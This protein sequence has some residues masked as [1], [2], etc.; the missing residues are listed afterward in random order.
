L[1]HL[2]KLNGDL[3]AFDSESGVL[4]LLDEIAYAVLEAWVENG[5]RK[6]SGKVLA[7]LADQ[8]GSPA[9]ECSVEIEEAAA[10]GLMFAENAPVDISQLY[11]DQPRIKSMCLHL[12]HDCN[13]RCKYCFAGTG[14]FGTGKRSMLDVETGRKAVDFLIEASGPRRNLDIDFFGG[15]PLLNWPVVVA[16]TDY[17]EKKAAETG[18]DIRLTITTNAVLLDDEKTEFINRHFKNCVLSIDGRPEVHDRMRPDAGRHGSYD[19]VAA[20]IRSF[21]AARGD[22]EYYLRGTYTHNNLDFSED[23]LH[24][25]TLGSQVSIEPVVSPDGSGYEIRPEDVNV[26][27]AEYEKLALKMDQ[28]NQAGEG[29]NFFHFMID[30]SGGP[31]ALKRLKGCGVGTE[32]CAVTPDGDIYPCHQFVGESQFRMGSVLREDGD[33]LPVGLDHQ[34]QDQFKNLLVP[35]KP[36]CRS[37]WARYFCSGGCA[38][39]AWHASGQVDGIYETGCALQKKRLECALWLQTRVKSDGGS[40]S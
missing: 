33:Q 38:A 27:E 36:A 6:P 40:K 30:L 7:T 19:R 32:Y 2:F 25:A 21:V 3:L 1:L 16:L 23:V 22:R 18:K 13:L 35:D 14:D 29:F 9:A 5:G 11:P 34:V 20:H 4:H 39:N 10:S 15:E 8:W 31:C 12:C 24:L 28:L 37:C 17:C 26:L